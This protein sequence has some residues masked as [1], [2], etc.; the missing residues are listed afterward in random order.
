M[1]AAANERE[2]TQPQINANE[3]EYYGDSVLKIFAAKTEA[4]P[5]F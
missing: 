1:N 4:A 3:R 2:R 5:A